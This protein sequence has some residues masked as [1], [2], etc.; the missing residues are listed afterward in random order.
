MAKLRNI[1]PMSIS[2]TIV[3]VKNKQFWIGLAR[4]I[5]AGERGTKTFFFA[6]VQEKFPG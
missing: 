2:A 1:D 6:I 5:F 4:S 3:K